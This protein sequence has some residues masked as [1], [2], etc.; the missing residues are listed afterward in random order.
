MNRGSFAGVYFSFV[1]MFLL[2]SFLKAGRFFY[3]A[4]YFS[5]LFI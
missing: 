5:E 1:V 4:R 2:F 3:I